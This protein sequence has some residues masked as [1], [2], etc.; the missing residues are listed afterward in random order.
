MSSHPQRPS[1]QIWIVF[2]SFSFLFVGIVSIWSFSL[3]APGPTAI[4]QT[5][6]PSEHQQVHTSPVVNVHRVDSPAQTTLAQATL[7]PM[8][9]SRTIDLSATDA[10]LQ[11]EIPPTLTPLSK[12]DIILVVTATAAQL[13]QS[14]RSPSENAVDRKFTY[15]FPVR[16]TRVSYGPYH[17]GY[18]ATDIFCPPGSEF[19]A[20]ID[21]VVDF[22][23][24]TDEWNPKT[25]R[26]E[27]RGGLSVAVIGDDGW[28][29]YGS[30]LS[31]IAEGIA[32]GVRVSAGQ[33]LGYTGN[34]GNARSTPPHLHFGISYPTTPDDW[35]TRRGQIP[36]YQYL[37]AWSKG[38]MKTPQ[39]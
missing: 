30:H 27:F 15:V 29:Y 14:T 18:P 38:D 36:P 23:S 8:K 31:A 39:P 24:Y 21:G 12:E 35:K 5:A 26:P 4:S 13:T 16:A 9:P 1:D 3:T 7:I 11:Q 25:D 2:F 33:V 28:R 34:S 10:A 37:V 19:V 17:H 6:T 32:P 22:V 20:P